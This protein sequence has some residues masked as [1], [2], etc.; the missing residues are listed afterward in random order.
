MSDT[1]F[2]INRIAAEFVQQNIENF[3]NTGKDVLKGAANAIRLRLN[4]SYK[5]YLQC[6]L[7]RYSRAKS[8][9]IRDEPTYL[10]NFYVPMGLTSKGQLIQASVCALESLNRFVVITGTGGSGKSMM[11]R[12]LLLDG[13]KAKRVPIFLELRELN[14]TPQSLKEFIYSTL[15]QNS[16]ALDDL[17]I[18]RALKA[19]HFLLL[20]DGFDEIASAIRKRVS[21]ELIELAKVY[22][23]NLIC[24]SSRP[25]NEFS[26]WSSFSVCAIQSLDL[27]QA[28]ELIEKLPFDPDLKAKFLQELKGG[29]FKR[30][31]SF[32]SNPLLL[33]IML[34]TFGQSADIPSKLNVFYNQ[35]YEALFQR[36]DA[37]KGGFQRTRRCKLDIQDF[38]R[39]F[40]AFAI[41]TYDKR[42]FQFTQSEALEYLEKSK[43][44][45]R[46]KFNENDYL[47]DTEQAVCLLI[48]DGLLIAFAHRSFQEY[49]V[50]RF[51]CDSKPEVQEKLIEKY[52]KNF[53]ADSV[54]DL[55][56]EMNPGLME[57]CLIVP[58][59]ER[60]QKYLKVKR[61][62]G[63]THFLRYLK[64]EF[65]TIE[66]SDGSIIGTHTGRETR[67]G[68]LVSFA[69]RHWGN[70]I[71]FSF[72]K[73][74]SEGDI[75]RYFAEKYDPEKKDCVIHVSRLTYRDEIVRDLATHGNFFS[76]HTLESVFKLKDALLE[77]HQEIGAT[78]D[79]ILLR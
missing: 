11:M 67:Y 15:R 36:H 28:C 48:E 27:G 54:F 24:V 21:K 78:L 30:H 58:Q 26:G 61:K 62:V 79:E 17:Y 5:E 52:R 29:L 18:E 60:L 16:F 64:S 7:A 39:V 46:I 10:Y 76:I 25:D 23:Q 63:I 19:G 6:V 73:N 37:L 50:A 9:F 8:F 3:Y 40:S 35:A 42:L 55:L 33:S 1:D 72:L 57:R 68:P 70:L 14:Q 47:L 74:D 65:R 43:R 75:Y 66:I 51:I 49:F 34:L 53:F 56:T 12:H 20:L 13:I 59:L 22:D 31:I 41:Q 44:I 4:R 2:D 32:L 69:L 77:K 45:L 38:A 71:D